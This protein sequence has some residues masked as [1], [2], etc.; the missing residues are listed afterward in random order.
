MNK[1]EEKEFLD[2]IESELKIIKANELKNLKRHNRGYQKVS[3]SLR[4]INESYLLDLDI[5]DLMSVMTD[6][7]LIL[8]VKQLKLIESKNKLVSKQ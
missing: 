7:E 2:S 5:K 1:Q 3:D 4:T 8:K 6:R